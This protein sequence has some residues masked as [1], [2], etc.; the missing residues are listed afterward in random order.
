M[1]LPAMSTTTPTT[2]RPTSTD[3]PTDPLERFDELLF[4]NP[5]VC[6]H[7]FARI[8]DHH[9]IHDHQAL[10]NGNKPTETLERAKDGVV[11]Q[12]VESQDTYG[13]RYSTATRTFCGRC[14][15]QSGRAIGDHI[16]SLQ[17]FRRCCDNIARRLHEQGYYPD[18]DA[19][20]AT[21]L[22]LK[23][24]QNHQ[25]K[26]REILAAAVHR[27][28]ENGREAAGRRGLPRVKPAPSCLQR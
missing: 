26:D 23:R 2:R 8:R 15:S 19:L 16:Y 21:A 18:L 22:T 5:E 13:V 11:G 12:A 20:Y 27:A 25:G 9:E 10:G 7:C 4:A 3:T 1:V 14:G 24:K 17:S 6:S 28:I